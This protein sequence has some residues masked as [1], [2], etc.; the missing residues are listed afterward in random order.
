MTGTQSLARA[1]ET[2]P[3]NENGHIPSP[4]QKRRGG[5]YKIFGLE[6]PVSKN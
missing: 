1:V 3:A 6:N 5:L 2:A 4:R